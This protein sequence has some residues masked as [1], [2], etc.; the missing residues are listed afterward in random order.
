MGDPPGDPHLFPPDP[1]YDDPNCTST[2]QIDNLKSLRY[3]SQSNGP[4][5]VIS[6]S[7]PDGNIG[8]KHP[9]II[10]KKIQDHKVE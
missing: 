3:N 10:G 6:M 4:Y 5:Y 8:T 1:N 2:L 7:D 9:M